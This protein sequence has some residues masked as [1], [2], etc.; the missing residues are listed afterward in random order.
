EDLRLRGMRGGAKPGIIGFRQPGIHAGEL[1]RAGLEEQVDVL[2]NFFL[3]SAGKALEKSEVNEFHGNQFCCL[4]NRLAIF[5][6]R[7][8]GSNGLEMYSFMPAL[9]QFCI[10]SLVT[11][12][13]LDMIGMDFILSFIC[14]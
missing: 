7:S 6:T 9:K 12:A 11:L 1:F 4:R 8:F 14:G 10:S 13:V 3:V 5:R 2:G